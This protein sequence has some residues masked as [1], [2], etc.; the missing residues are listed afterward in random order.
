MNYSTAALLLNPNCRAIRVSYEKDPKDGKPINFMIK[1]TF[2]DTIAV[3]D[4][5]VVETSNHDHRY[6]VTTCKVVE[7]DV[8]WEPN[9]S[10]N[11]TWIIHKVDVGAFEKL[12]AAEGEMI[13]LAKASEKTRQREELQKK[14]FEHV[15]KDDL[16]KLSL[17][18]MDGNS[19]K[20]IEHVPVTPPSS[21]PDDPQF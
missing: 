16:D 7:T 20:T 10:E 1:K 3:G 21:K 19:I 8:E 9:T 12:K 5:V 11:I 13:S 17:A 15:N 18:S 2:D 4:L 14:M 6:G